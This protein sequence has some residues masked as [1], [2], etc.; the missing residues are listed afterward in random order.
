MGLKTVVVKIK[1][2]PFFGRDEAMHGILGIFFEKEFVPQKSVMKF[3]LV[4]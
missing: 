4:I 3:G 1:W 2:D